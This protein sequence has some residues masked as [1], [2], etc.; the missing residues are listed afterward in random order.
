M[1]RTCSTLKRQEQFLMVLVKMGRMRTPNGFKKRSGTVFNRGK[2]YA[3]DPE[4]VKHRDVFHNSLSQINKISVT[5]YILFFR[6]PF[7][8]HR[9]C[10]ILKMQEQFLMVLV[11]MG[12]M[13]TPNGFKKS[14]GTVFNRGKLYAPDPEGVS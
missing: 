14:S 7:F 1:H 2:L 12:R 4:G 8:M 13:R 5:H 6:G 9:T 3:P 10:S 11:K